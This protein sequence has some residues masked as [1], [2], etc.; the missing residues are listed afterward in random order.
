MELT[1][2]SNFSLGIG[3]TTPTP[4][5]RSGDDSNVCFESVEKVEKRCKPGVTNGSFWTASDTWMERGKFK[6]V[7]SLGIPPNSVELE[8]ELTPPFHQWSWNWGI[9]K[10][11][12]KESELECG[13]GN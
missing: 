10:I 2:N 3:A 8:L 4:I 6:Q 11:N 1:P 9:P 12:S 7:E 5:Q 13:I